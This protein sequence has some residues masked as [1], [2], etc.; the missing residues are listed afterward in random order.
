MLLYN[1]LCIFSKYQIRSFQKYPLVSRARNFCSKIRKNVLRESY[2][3]CN[4]VIFFYQV[5]DDTR[6]KKYVKG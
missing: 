5:Y 3:R 2:N 4:Y 6:F 1:I